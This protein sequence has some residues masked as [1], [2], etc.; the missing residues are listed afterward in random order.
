MNGFVSAMAA[1]KEIDWYP[2]LSK[3]KV[4]THRF[5]TARWPTTGMLLWVLAHNVM[6]C[7]ESLQYF[8]CS[9]CVKKC[10]S[11]PM[12]GFLKIK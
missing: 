7:Q 6:M 2:I 4:F 1:L 3:F 11:P 9:Q 12:F 8:L 5:L 10:I